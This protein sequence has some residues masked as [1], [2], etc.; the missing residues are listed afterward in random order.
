MQSAKS[1]SFL[2]LAFHRQLLGESAPTR[3]GCREDWGGVLGW[4]EGKLAVVLRV[5]ANTRRSLYPTDKAVF[6]SSR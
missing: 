6:G 4:S 2:F 1:R 5:Y 3:S